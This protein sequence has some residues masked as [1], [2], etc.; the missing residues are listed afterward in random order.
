MLCLLFWLFLHASW[1]FFPI[2]W[3][4]VWYSSFLVLVAWLA[5]VSFVYLLNPK[6][7]YRQVADYCW[8]SFILLIF[9]LHMGLSYV[10]LLASL[11]SSALRTCFW[12]EIRKCPG[13]K[14]IRSRNGKIYEEYEPKFLDLDIVKKQQI[15]NE[16][17]TRIVI[18]I[19]KKKVMRY[20]ANYKTITRTST[21]GY[22][23]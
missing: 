13:T 10:I 8:R 18:P 20:C 16:W 12:P 6:S 23:C 7:F 21:P 9:L 2:L 15:W 3:F 4:I 22:W 19:Y 11:P 14:W 1:S 17:N 5:S